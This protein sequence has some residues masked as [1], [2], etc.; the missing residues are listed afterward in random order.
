MNIY[1]LNI[2]NQYVIAAFMIFVLP[3]VMFPIILLIGKFSEFG[4]KISGILATSGIFI[5]FI[6]SWYVYSKGTFS[7]DPSYYYFNYEFPWF[8][9]ITWGVYVDP[10]SITMALMVSGVSFLIHMFAIG[11]MG[12]DPNKHIYF[13]ETSLFTGGMLG[14]VL[15]ANLVMLFLFWELVGLCSYLLIG[16]WYFKPNAASAAKK[17]FIVTRVGDVLLI[18]GLAVLYWATINTNN[19]L[20]IYN[21]DTQI[22]MLINKMHSNFQLA[23]AGALILGGA[24]GKSSQFP[25]HVWIPDAMEGPTTVSALIHAATMVTAGIYL[26][27][28]VYPIYIYGQPWVGFLVLYIG[29][30]TA[31]LAGT[32]GIVVNDIKRILAYST[33]SQLGYMLSALGVGIVIGESTVGYSLYHLVVHAFLKALLFLSAGSILFML[34][35]IRDIRKMGGL[36]KKMPITITAMFLGALTLIGFPP[37]AGYFSKDAII[38]LSYYG[39]MENTSL[40]YAWFLLLIG[41]FLTTVYTFRMFFVVSLGKPKSYAAENAKDPP[42]VMIVPLIILSILSIIYGVFQSDFYNFF[43]GVYNMSTFKFD[44]PWYIEWLPFIFVLLGLLIAYLYYATYKLS[45]ENFARKSGIIYKIVKNKYYLDFLFTNII[46][47]RFMLILA[48]IFN[49]IDKYV[50]DGIVNGIGWIFKNLSD[51]FKKIQV[52][53]VQYYAAIMLGGLIAILITVIILIGGI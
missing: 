8:A 24:I 18:L 52:G 1:Q 51:Y 45:A 38:S 15:S 41:T 50:I 32:I 21:L 4:K 39:Y 30:F 53:I 3:I 22:P 43:N 23:L 28:R 35:D 34:L 27:A 37:L 29:A 2:W 49:L 5:S 16:F 46:A 48:K 13:A 10:L 6:L 40:F 44:I 42:W 19:T 7:F 14:L 17:A 36:W 9:N 25:L 26:V 12:K 31:F 47:E 33:I 20:S 11:Y